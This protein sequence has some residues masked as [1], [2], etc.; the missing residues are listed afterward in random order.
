MN[1]SDTKVNEL[2][3]E[4]LKYLDAFRS[5]LSEITKY[6]LLSR[7]EEIELAQRKDMGD[8]EAFKELV[9]HNLRFVLKIALSYTREHGM[10]LDIIQ[11][12]N[13]GLMKAAEMYRWNNSSG[14]KLTTYADK[15]IRVFINNYIE[16]NYRNNRISPISAPRGTRNKIRVIQRIE[17]KLGVDGSTDPE[18]IAVHSDAIKYR[19]TPKKILQLKAFEDLRF[20]AFE[21]DNSDDG[22]PRS[23]LIEGPGPLPDVPL[24]QEE[25]VRDVRRAME[26]LTERDRDILYRRM[27]DETLKSLGNCYELCRERIRQIERKSIKKLRRADIKEILQEHC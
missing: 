21:G 22:P 27:K 3:S 23:E 14:A 11:E 25:L 7:E 10:L 15:R 24:E 6:P 2:Y 9:S 5:Y 8:R 13:M 12:G 26:I 18:R 16:R 17:N 4:H 1:K 20:V 19:L